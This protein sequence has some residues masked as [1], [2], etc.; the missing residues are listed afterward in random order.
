[1]KANDGLDYSIFQ[2]GTDFANNIYCLS[3]KATPE[4]ETTTSTRTAEGIV[5]FMKLIIKNEKIKVKLAKKAIHKKAVCL[6]FAFLLCMNSFASVVS[7]NDGSAFVTKA[8]FE[9]LKNNFAEQIQQYNQS[10][11]SKIDGAIASYL[12]GIQLAK[13]ETLES[14]LNKVNDDCND[15]YLDGTTPKKYGYRCMAKAWTVPTTQKPEGAIT[16]FFTGNIIGSENN[17]RAG[18]GFSRMALTV[19]TRTGLYDVAIP[20]SGCRHGLYMMLKKYN[21]KYYPTNTYSDIRY[22]YYVAGSGAAATWSG[23][24]PQDATDSG[25]VWTFP[26]FQITET[27][28]WKINVDNAYAYWNAATSHDWDFIKVFYGGTYENT[29][30]INVV[31][32]TG[33]IST[34]NIYGL[35]TDNLTK[36]RVQ[37]NY[38]DWQGYGWNRFFSRKKDGTNWVLDLNFN[39]A[40]T[41]NLRFY[42]NCHPYD[43]A[44]KPSEFIDYNATRAYNEGDVAIYGGLPVF[45]AT[46]TGEVT[47]KIK[48]KSHL[49][50]DVYVGLQKTQ[51]LNNETYAIDNS[52][53][54]RDESGNKYT[55]NKF[56]RDKVY[57]FVMDVEKD[58]VIW[59]K[60]YDANSDT[61][62]TG[63]I[64]TDIELT[65]E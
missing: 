4:T 57:T 38:Y 7:D 34:S 44:V 15:S 55:S 62:F 18:A 27:E 47:M 24:P 45:K 42:F 63:A 32:V 36:M 9:G 46:S 48:F 28:Y 64:T 59:I 41:P 6:F 19:D 25:V 8:E 21:N 61:G 52:L 1:M 10:I 20:S 16:N 56:E 33:K 17:S 31:P 60:T 50:H 22:R 54:L 65:A 23:W 5:E 53:G 29:E 35:L 30:S 2:Y 14:L 26:T 39:V 12:A 13:K 43:N 58:N 3:D 49:N 37:D 51:F 11:D 40:N